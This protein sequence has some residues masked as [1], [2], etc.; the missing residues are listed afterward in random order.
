MYHAHFGQT[1]E[2]RFRWLRS[3]GLIRGSTEKLSQGL[4]FLFT[5]IKAVQ[6]SDDV[7]DGSK[8]GVFA[9]LKLGDFSE[10]G[11]T[12]LIEIDFTM[13]VLESLDE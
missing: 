10:P 7:A 3:L 13:G 5:G 8:A 2:R 6:K 9:L 4:E 1:I 11:D 12:S